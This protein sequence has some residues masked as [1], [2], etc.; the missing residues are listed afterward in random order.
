MGRSDELDMTNSIT[1]FC[2]S[3]VTIN[4]IEMAI[5]DFVDA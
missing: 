3:W 1:K 2:V 4:V 5:S